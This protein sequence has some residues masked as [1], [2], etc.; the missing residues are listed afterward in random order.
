MWAS[1]MVDPLGLDMLDQ[2]GVDRV[3]WAADYPHNES[4]FGY[5]QQSVAAVVEA[6]GP[7]SAAL[8][9][10]DNVKNFLG[11]RAIPDA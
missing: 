10:S 11:L 6:V 4:T 1:F 7:D 3:M 2:I 9:V 8:I 5:S